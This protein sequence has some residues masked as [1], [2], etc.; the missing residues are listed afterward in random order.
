MTLQQQ[1]VRWGPEFTPDTIR[2][3]VFLT[4]GI[5]LISA[6]SEPLLNILFNLPGPAYLFS[7]SWAGL[8]HGYLWQIVTYLFFQDTGGS[9]LSLSF[10]IGLAFNLYLLWIMGTDLLEKVGR[11]PFLR[12]Y[13]TA[14]IAAGL[15]AL[16]AMFFT[17]QYAILSGPTPAIIAVL[18]AWT[19]FN[20]ESELYIFFLFS[21]K[22]KWLWG[23]LAGVFLISSLSHL[24]WV[25]FSYYGMALLAGYVY[26]VAAWDQRGPFS[27]L[28]PFDALFSSIGRFLRRGGQRLSSVRPGN[29]KKGKIID[30]KTGEPLLD[31]NLFVDAMLEKI[32]KNG[33]SSLT[34]KERQRLQEISKA[35]QKK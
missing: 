33:E 10:L 4:G 5:S 19:L 14:G 27:W 24:D 34:W 23:V 21:I 3:L 9:G 18:T 29:I 13:I 16:A 8:Q 12:F 7:L 15:A 20:P 1:T 31:D 11:W 6:L 17:G 32:S 22:A 2:N 28:R 26:A 25:S 35:R 30:F